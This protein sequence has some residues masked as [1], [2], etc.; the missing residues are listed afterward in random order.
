MS[1]GPEFNV[2]VTMG[3]VTAPNCFAMVERPDG[4]YD[5]DDNDAGDAEYE[6]MSIHC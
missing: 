3:V 6:S 2:I 4:D 1:E 5:C